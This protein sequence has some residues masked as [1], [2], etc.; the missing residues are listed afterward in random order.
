MSGDETRPRTS[1]LGVLRRLGSLGAH[2]RRVEGRLLLLI[3]AAAAVLLAFVLLAGNVVDGD[4]RAFDERLLLALRDPQDAAQPLGPRWLREVM[5]DIT[6]LG[7]NAVLF[8]MTA[9]VAVFMLLTG[10]RRTAQLV[11]VSIVTGALLNTGLKLAFARP[12]PDLVPHDVAVYTLSFPSGHALLSATV[13]LTLAALL[14]RTQ[15]GLRVKVFVIAVAVTLTLLIGVS[16]VYL[17]V[18]W[19]TDVLAG[20]TLGAAWA[21]VCWIVMVR[22]QRHGVVE[23]EAPK[24]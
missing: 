24:M 13:Y 3:G 2:A 19:P 10:R 8:L 6:G 14:A 9:A 17:G 11:V 4:T 20:W 18:H 7:G 5:R 23:P 21:L 16:R 22:L 12:R 1:R 15:P